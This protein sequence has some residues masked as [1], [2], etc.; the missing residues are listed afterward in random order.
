MAL[1]AFQPLADEPITLAINLVVG[2]K[3]ARG[4][5]RVAVGTDKAVHVER[6][7]VST[8]EPRLVRTNWPSISRWHFTHAIVYNIIFVK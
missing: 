7:F 2:R 5:H 1:C 8:M 4:D 6:A 3:E